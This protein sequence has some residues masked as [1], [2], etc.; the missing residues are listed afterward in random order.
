MDERVVFNGW[1]GLFRVVIVGTLAYVALVLLLRIS[2]KRTLSKMNAFD[3]VVTVAL[4]STLATVILS[5]DVALAEGVVAFALLVGL[6][7]GITWL[8]V[9]SATVSQL[10]KA[11][12]TLLLYQGHLLP[13]PMRRMRV[14]EAEVHAAVREQGIATLADVEA[15]VLETDGSFAVVKRTQDPATALGGLG[16]LETAERHGSGQ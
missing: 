2:G 9:R 1:T 7:F 10:I 5:K 12:P 6:Q 8:S 11:E 3:L 13:E 15:V 14:L 16:E 4:G